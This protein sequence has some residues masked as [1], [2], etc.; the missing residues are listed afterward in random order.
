MKG[1][2]DIAKSSLKV[3]LTEAR[4]LARIAA[5]GNYVRELKNSFAELARKAQ[6]IDNPA[7]AEICQL[8]MDS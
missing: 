4:K 2:E 5:V 8:E 3:R 7:Q 1:L 6:S